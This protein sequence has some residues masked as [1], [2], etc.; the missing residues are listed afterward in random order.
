MRVGII[1]IYHESNTFISVPTTLDSFRQF[2]LLTGADIRSE[3]GAAHHELGGF[4]QGLDEADI[5]AVPLLLASAMPSGPVTAA[6]LESLLEIM[7]RELDGAGRL[8][9]LLLGPHGA[10]V[11]ESQRDMDGYWLSLVRERCGPEFPI[12]ATIDPHANL[13]QPMV[14]ACDAIVAYRSNPHLDQRQRG[15]EACSLLVGR[16]R[17]TIQPTQ[18]AAFPPV[19]INIERQHTTQEPCLSMY[20]FADKLL[21]CD[22]VLSNSIALGFPFADVVEMGSSFIAVTDDDAP[23][24]SEVAAEMADYLVNHRAQFIPEFISIEEAIDKA[25]RS[26]GPVCLLDVGDNVGGGSA[27]DGTLIA[28]AIHARGGPRTLVCINDPEAVSL[29]RQAGSGARLPLEIGGKVDNMHGPPLLGDVTVRSLHEGRFVETEPRH[30]GKASHD[31]GPT[32]VVET[33]TQLTIILT[34]HRTAP[35]S[36]G[37]ITSCDLDPIT[38]QILIA[39][40]VHA[41][42]AAYAPISKRL[43][44]VNTPGSTTADMSHFE[45]KHRRKPLFPFEEI[46]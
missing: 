35:F 3:Y 18:A 9:G 4:F 40:G 6:A 13:S 24:A 11:A 12:F 7:W 19:T 41:P 1:G 46:G 5:E 8:D 28:Q 37:Q 16:L 45:F 42:V 32:A 29:A 20:Q 43:I 34:T 25:T 14:D 2:A 27:A 38:F 26:E 10:A 31:M 21:E 33:D 36:L 15:L 17:G 39:K 23:L 22:R 30:G 44:R